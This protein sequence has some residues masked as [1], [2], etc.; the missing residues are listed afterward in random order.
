[1]KCVLNMFEWCTRSSNI[2]QEPVFAMGVKSWEGREVFLKQ[3]SCQM[4][5]VWPLNILI[6]LL[7]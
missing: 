2:N 1:M 4:I 3:P 5:L 6:N 7:E